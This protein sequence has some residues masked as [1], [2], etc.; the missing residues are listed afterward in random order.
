M[1]KGKP[2][3]KR[4]KFTEEDYINITKWAGLGLSEQQ[5]ADNLG[6]SVLPPIFEEKYLCSRIIFINGIV[7]QGI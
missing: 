5:I 2:G 7:K 4:H 3:R 1:E 6:V